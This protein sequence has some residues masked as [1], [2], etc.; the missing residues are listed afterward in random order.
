M[1]KSALH[2]D[3]FIEIKKTYNRFLSILLIV[4]L[5]VAFFAGL[6]VCRSDMELSADTYY[7]D[8]N[9]MDFRVVST[10]GLTE[11]DI[12][13]ISKVDGVEAVEAAHTK[14][15]LLRLNNNEIVVKT[16]SL[17]ENVN[18]SYLVDGRLPT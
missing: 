2:K 4:A 11:D 14:D 10:L 13:A 17:N 9:L 6:R 3:F 12:E 16:Y 15:V 7:D 1:K 18:K 8:M 5:G